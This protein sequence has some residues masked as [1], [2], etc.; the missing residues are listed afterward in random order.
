MILTTSE[1]I[2]DILLRYLPLDLVQKII[3]IKDRMIERETKIYW[4]SITPKY[5]FIFFGFLGEDHNKI[6]QN[7]LI[8]RINGNF[9]KLKEEMDE[10]R[11]L[12]LQN[13]E[14]AEAWNRVRF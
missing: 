8:R 7:T 13:E 14:W 12:K 10:L 1:E 3:K 6:A 9:K 4:R 5:N 11:Y 2:K